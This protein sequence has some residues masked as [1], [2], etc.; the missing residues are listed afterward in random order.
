MC[1]LFG[2]GT[3]RWATFTPRRRHFW[4]G[5]CL[6]L[7]KTPIFYRVATM[8]A[9][10]YEKDRKYNI[11]KCKKYKK[12]QQIQKKW[13]T[14]LPTSCQRRQFSIE[15]RKSCTKIKKRQKIHLADAFCPPEKR[16]KGNH[17]SSSILHSKVDSVSPYQ[18]IP[19]RMFCTGLFVLYYNILYVAKGQKIENISL[20]MTLVS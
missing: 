3:E 19:F 5:R 14:P 1:L 6:P 18:F 17:Y 4:D 12:M 11:Q 15:L 9:Q 7:S 20:S 2:S 10:K 16:F 13:P 8:P